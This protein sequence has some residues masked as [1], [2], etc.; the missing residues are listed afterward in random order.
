MSVLFAATYPERVWA[1]VLEGASARYLWAPDYPW[2]I[3]EDEWRRESEQDER[4]SGTPE[5]SLARAA[6]IAPSA[7]DEDKRALATLIRHGAS[8]GAAAA[9]DRMNQEIDVRQVLP[10]IRVP[11]LILN[12]AQEHPFNVQSARYLAEH[13]AGPGTSSCRAP[14]MP[15][16]PAT[17]SRRSGRSRAS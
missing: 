10:A 6:A 2:G 13:I 5:H 1:L 12:R 15:R 17:Q 16:S 3:P 7:G 14:S 11:T 4:E 8:P 9:L